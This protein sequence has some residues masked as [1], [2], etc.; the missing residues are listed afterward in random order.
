MQLK[1]V[2][3]LSF[4]DALKLADDVRMHVVLERRRSLAVEVGRRIESDHCLADDIDEL[5]PP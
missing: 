4:I 1:S 5:R 3:I 2:A